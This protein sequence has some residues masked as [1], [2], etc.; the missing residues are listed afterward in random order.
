MYM[1]IGNIH[2]ERFGKSFEIVSFDWK[3]LNLP[4]G[5]GNGLVT[6]ANTNSTCGICSLNLVCRNLSDNEKG[7][8]SRRI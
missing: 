4:L 1:E 3:Y 6:N 7:K 2:V 5:K 8:G